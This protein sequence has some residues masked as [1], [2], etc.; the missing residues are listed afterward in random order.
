[1]KIID[2]IPIAK[3]NSPG[4]TFLFHFQRHFCRRACFR[5]CKKKDIPAIV[6]AVSDAK[7]S[8]IS[9]KDSSFTMKPIKSVISANFITPEFL[10]ALQRNSRVLSL[11]DRLRAQRFLFRK[12]YWKAVPD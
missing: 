12:R 9:L 2:V 3:G 11:Y 8:K 4:K 10:E 6:S 5:P 1:M 7:E